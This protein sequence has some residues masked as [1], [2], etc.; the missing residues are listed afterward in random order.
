[1]LKKNG[2]TKTDFPLNSTSSPTINPDLQE[3]PLEQDGENWIV[4]VYNNETNTWE[5][6]MTILIIATGCDAEEAH[7]ET[8]EVDHYGKCV[9]HR[10]SQEECEQAAKVISTIGIGVEATPDDGL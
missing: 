6:V 9:V 2:M 4:T 1:M 8:W 10:A 3:T 7:I 5:E